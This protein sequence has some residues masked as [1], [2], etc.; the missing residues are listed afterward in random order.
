MCWYT[1]SEDSLNI[2]ISPYSQSWRSKYST[3][4]NLYSDNSDVQ[5]IWT[6]PKNKFLTIGDYILYCVKSLQS[7][8]IFL[9]EESWFV[10]SYFLHLEKLSQGV[11]KDRSSIIS[12]LPVHQCT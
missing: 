2:L 1:V 5:L 11:R 6:A 4:A 12:L 10:F 9:L 8:K 3:L 7:T